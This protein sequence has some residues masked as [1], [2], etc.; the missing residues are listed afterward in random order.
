MAK[1]DDDIGKPG[2]P[3]RARAFP[4]RLWMFA[5]L[6]TAGAVAGGWYTW[7]YRKQA[8]SSTDE[9]AT[10]RTNKTKLETQ[11]A[12]AT[13]KADSCLTQLQATLKA[14]TD[15]EAQLSAKASPDGLPKDEA[16]VKRLAAIDE[17]QRQLV[18]MAEAGT[19][20]VTARRGSLVLSLPI[21]P[22][23]GP[24][25][26]ELTK[27]G[28]LA[29]L[30]VGITLKRYPERRFQITGHTDDT[31]AKAPFKDNWELS[32]A[33]AL[34]VT[35]FLIQAGMDPRNLLAAGA[36]D[37]DPLVKGSKANARIEITQLP[38]PTELPILPASLGPDTASATSGPPAPA[39]A[40]GAAAGS[41]KGP[42]EAPPPADKK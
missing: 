33:R 12:D 22:L 24:G 32:S 23:F 19:V 17:I 16:S 15:L 37:S 3:L 11:A 35:R 7:Q 5:I 36:A 4:W 40:P 8:T 38:L 27:P 1:Y 14:K 30:E 10:L 18:K 28:E 9:L 2:K 25:T 42:A 39:G 26:A 20:K 41:A 21:D 34:A 13:K 29:I 6:M 31:P